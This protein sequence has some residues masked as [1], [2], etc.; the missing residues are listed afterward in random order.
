MGVQLNIAPIHAPISLGRSG[1][2]MMAAMMRTMPPQTRRNPG[3]APRSRKMPK[4]PDRTLNPFIS[5]ANT[6]SRKY[7]VYCSACP[8]KHA[9]KIGCVRKAKLSST[10][11]VPIQRICAAIAGLMMLASRRRGFSCI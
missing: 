10:S 6:N 7:A 3:F 11:H 1:A 2:L 8:A 9:A 4:P 5:E